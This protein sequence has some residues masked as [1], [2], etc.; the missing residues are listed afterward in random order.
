MLLFLMG[1]TTLN[2]KAETAAFTNS[3]QNKDGISTL[4]II[5]NIVK[6]EKATDVS[7]SSSLVTKI[8]IVP[9]TP[10][11]KLDQDC[12]EQVSENLFHLGRPLALTE[13]QDGVIW[14]AF[15]FGLMKLFGNEQ[16]EFS[17]KTIEGCEKCYAG[18]RLVVT[19]NGEVWVGV[20]GGL[21]HV[22]NEKPELI[23]YSDIFPENSNNKLGLRILLATKSGTLW[24]SDIQT[25]NVCAYK[26]NWNCF[27][28]FS[29]NENDQIVSAVALEENDI[30][31]GSEF[32]KIFEYKDWKLLSYDVNS[33]FPGYAGWKKIG[34]L[35]FDKKNGTLWAVETN[36]PNCAETFSSP[37]IG[38][39]KRTKDGHWSMLEKGFFD[40][41]KDNKCYGNLSS[42]TVDSNNQVWLGM[43]GRY[44]VVI[45]DG[46]EWKTLSGK[47]LPARQLLDRKQDQLNHIDVKCQIDDDQYI[48]NNIF[49]PEH[50][51]LL[52]LNGYSILRYKN[53]P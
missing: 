39:I 43:N 10:L 11:P 2:K 29:A 48:T 24:V 15:D 30:W 31:F 41:Y 44:G 52:V 25:G 34:S 16:K 28:P 49:A 37:G 13:S 23:P 32:G 38:V 12:W 36:P 42:I 40:R 33:L 20:S 17:F 27:N 4:T 21:I 47:M 45:Y 51:G 18:D 5:P 6:T 35:A 19:E 22:K 3:F 1:C 8:P 26:T 50:G 46:V 9:P 14:V 7:G 53:E